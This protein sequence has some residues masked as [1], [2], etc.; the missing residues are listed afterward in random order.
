MSSVERSAG[1]P[2]HPD[3]VL[4]VSFLPFPT[5]AL[6]DS[7]TA[8]DSFPVVFYAGSMTMTSLALT[9]TWLH[10]ARKHLL[11]RRWNRTRCACSASAP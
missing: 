11:N 6:G 8:D 4:T 2:E 3:V 9:L 1:G 5:A 7:P 10:A